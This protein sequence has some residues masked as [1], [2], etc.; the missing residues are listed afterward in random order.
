MK[1]AIYYGIQDIRVEEIDTPVCGKGEIKVKVHYCAICGT[2]VRIYLSGHKKVIPPAVIGHEITGVVEE[3]GSD[4]KYPEKIQKGDKVVLVT[5]IG[6][7]VCKMCRKGFYNLCPDTKAIGYFYPGGYAEYVIVPAPAVK[8]QA[9]IKL[10]EGVSLKEGALIE[11]LSCA[12]NGQNYLN[13]GEGDIVVIYGGGPIGFMH[14]VLAL[15]EGAEK[16]IMVDPVYERLEKFGRHFGD[17]LLLDP[18]K[19]NVKDEV[20]KQTGG[21]G[22]DVV[23]TA[24]PAKQAQIEGLGLLGSKGR[25]SL[26]GGLPKDDSFINIDANLIH[27]KE[28]SVFGSFAS[29]RRDFI[30]AAK[31]ISERKIDASKFISCVVPLEKIN[32]GIEMVRQGEVLKCVVEINSDGRP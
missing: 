31:L 9:V 4:V 14:A 16:V 3:I 12:I 1:A 6:C 7:G 2:D 30:K 13:I 10:P 5:S 23:I 8:Q 19:I 15:A 22:A 11:A 32:E 25:I 29:N 26:F 17:I 18:K 21:Y 24:C 28:L 27:Y 20:M